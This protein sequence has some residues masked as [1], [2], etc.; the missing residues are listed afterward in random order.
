[1]ASWDRDIDLTLEFCHHIVSTQFPSFADQQPAELGSGWDNVCIE[2]PDGTVFRLPSRAVGGELMEIELL[3]LPQLADKLPIPI[4][5]ISFAGVPGND[6]PYSFMGYQKLSGV[7]GDRHE[8]TRTERMEGARSL[9]RFLAELHQIPPFGGLPTGVFSKAWLE[10]RIG[11]RHRHLL[12]ISP[13]QADWA[14]P[15]LRL[16]AQI[17][18]L[19]EDEPAR[20]VCHGDLYPRHVLVDEGR[21]SGVIDWGDVQL[22]HRSADL[23][24]AFTLLEAVERDEFWQAYGTAPTANTVALA[25]LKAILY[26]LSLVGYGLDVGDHPIQRL[27]E[28]IGRRVVQ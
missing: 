2:Y 25:R 16:T 14:Q 28:E 23:S 6:Y 9:G 4:P 21:V 8:W 19:C 12:Q 17:L 18:D 5:K 7:T 22:A 10:E 15:L 11:F 26:A 1:M 27:G 3:A 13:D 20:V 24:I